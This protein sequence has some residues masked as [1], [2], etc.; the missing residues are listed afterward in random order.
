MR[1]RSRSRSRRPG[2]CAVAIAA[3]FAATGAV[4]A[5]APSPMPAPTPSDGMA[6]SEKLCASCHAIDPGAA[7]V[8]RADVPTFRAIANGPKATPERLVA[9]IILPHPEMPGIALTRSELR[10]VVTY[11]MSLRK[12]P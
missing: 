5:Q 2:L 11:I 12:E 9:A 4:Q 8:P 7:V 3:W 6:I 1:Q 10:A